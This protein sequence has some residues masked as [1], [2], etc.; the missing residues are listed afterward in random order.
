MYA[1][2][3]G[4]D[5]SVGNGVPVGGLFC[6]DDTGGRLGMPILEAMA[7]GLPVIATGWSAQ[8]DFMNAGNAYP[9]RGRPSDSGGG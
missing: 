2:S 6:V 8:C 5:V 9:D 3:A 4:A 1:Q 7:C